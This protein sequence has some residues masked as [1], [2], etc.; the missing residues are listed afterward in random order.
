VAARPTPRTGFEIAARGIGLVGRD[1][2]ARDRL[3]SG[4]WMPGE[5][6]VSGQQTYATRD[7]VVLRLP[8]DGAYL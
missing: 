5:A 2:L 3:L 4:G 8:A 1:L 6:A 7:V